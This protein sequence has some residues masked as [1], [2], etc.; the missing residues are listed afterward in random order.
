MCRSVRKEISNCISVSKRRSTSL[1]VTLF[2]TRRYHT[3][4][5]ASGGTPRKKFEE[6][7]AEELM[8]KLV[9]SRNNTFNLVFR[10]LVEVST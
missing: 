8:Q 4:E 9:V 5:M 2:F 3:I 1:S 7:T 6:M 10:L